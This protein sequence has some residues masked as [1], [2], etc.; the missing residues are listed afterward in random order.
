[1]ICREMYATQQTL[2]VLV[3]PATQ[4]VTFINYGADEMYSN[5]IMALLASG[6]RGSLTAGDDLMQMAQG[7]SKQGALDEIYEYEDWVAGHYFG[8]RCRPCRK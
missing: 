1:M 3:V 4:T 7:D 5:A 2:F 6:P 8:A